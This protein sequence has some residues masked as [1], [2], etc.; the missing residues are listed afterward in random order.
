MFRWYDLPS[1]NEEE[2][3]AGNLTNEPNSVDQKLMRYAD[4]PYVIHYPKQKLSVV[5]GCPQW[6]TWTVAQ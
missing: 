1:I 3:D 4:L 5:V 6:F 2:L